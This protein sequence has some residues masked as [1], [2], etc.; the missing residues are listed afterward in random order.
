MTDKNGT[1]VVAGARCLFYVEGRDTWLEG[2]VRDVRD[3]GVWADHARVDDG[4]P[5]ND[6][7]RTNGLHVSSWASSREIEV[8]P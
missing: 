1:L 5:A 8:L 4:D 7:L 6:D 2:L 3:S